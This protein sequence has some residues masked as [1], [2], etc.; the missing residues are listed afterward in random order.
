MGDDD[1]FDEFAKESRAEQERLRDQ[2][3]LYQPVGVMR[4]WTGRSPDHLREVTAE[5][6]DEIHR[7]IA[8]IE[9]IIK[10]AA[11]LAKPP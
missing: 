8:R 7:E 9:A 2:L 3:R 6:V 11:V 1:A 10:F 4:L 5:R